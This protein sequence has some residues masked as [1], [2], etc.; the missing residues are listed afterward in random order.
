MWGDIS[1]WV[2]WA[3]THWGYSRVSQH[4]R[5]SLDQ[6]PKLAYT[7]ETTRWAAVLCAFVFFAFF[8]FV[9]E[10]REHYRLLAVTLAEFLG[11]TKS[12]KDA[13]TP[14]SSDVGFSLQF[15]PRVIEVQQIESITDIDSFSDRRSTWTDELDLK[16]KVP[17][18]PETV[19][20]P[21]SVRKTSVLEAVERV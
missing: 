17:R 7:L 2:S 18:V 13:A 9:G 12:T 4:P 10:A 1:P 11:F 8:G 14:I 3:D 20:D 16:H 6:N 15:A 21:A 5:I 19:L